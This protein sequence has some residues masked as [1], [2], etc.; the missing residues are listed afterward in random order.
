MSEEDKIKEI[1]L[2]KILDLKIVKILLFLIML[3]TCAI[4]YY[5]GLKK[6]IFLTILFSAISFA[7]AV[8]C[9]SIALKEKSNIKEI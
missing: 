1:D 7:S 2:N 8:F 6:I 9:L 3:I 4:A 5:F